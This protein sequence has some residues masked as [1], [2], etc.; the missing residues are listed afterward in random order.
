MDI[1]DLKEQ[2]KV[3]QNNVFILLLTISFLSMIVTIINHLINES[4]TNQIL[5]II[6]IV[7]FSIISSIWFI[8]FIIQYEKKNQ[9]QILYIYRKLVNQHNMNANQAYQ[10][11]SPKDITK[12]EFKKFPLFKYTTM[13]FSLYLK[14][15]SNQHKLYFVSFYQSSGN[16][17]YLKSSGLLY[18]YPTNTLI[19]PDEIISQMNQRSKLKSLEFNQHCY[20][21]LELKKQIPIFKRFNEKE[22]EK[23][24]SFGSDVLKFFDSISNIFE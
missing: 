15:Q 12:D 1:N 17:S 7:L 2:Y 6:G 5:M 22:R 10:V 8:W 9:E 13:R 19:K 18:A 24:L 3:K 14:N 20:I 11:I 21:Y 4:R 23:V 16:S